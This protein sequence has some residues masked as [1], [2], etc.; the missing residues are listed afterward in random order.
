MF[1]I[2]FMERYEDDFPCSNLDAIVTKIRDSG[3]KVEVLYKAFTDEQ[4]SQHVG[5]VTT[6]AMNRI[7]QQYCE[8]S[9]HELIT[10]TRRFDPTDCGY[11]DYRELLAVLR[12]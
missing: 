4:D 1:A 9:A 5:C 8:L 10:I 11:P 7:M 12:K 2:K 3:V 6:S